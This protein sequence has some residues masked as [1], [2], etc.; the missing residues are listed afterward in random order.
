MGLQNLLLSVFK[1][2]GESAIVWNRE[3]HHI[4]IYLQSPLL[5]SVSI[6]TTL[7]VHSK[8]EAAINCS[9]TAN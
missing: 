8:Q 6:L 3:W 9:V 1:K 7:Q 4:S 2:C 5:S